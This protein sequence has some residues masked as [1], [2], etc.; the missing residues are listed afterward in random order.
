MARIPCSL[1]WMRCC[2]AVKSTIPVEL[3]GASPLCVAKSTF[4][5]V[6]G[7][8]LLAN[9]FLI[10]SCLALGACGIVTGNVFMLSA[11]N[12]FWGMRDTGGRSKG[13]SDLSDSDHRLLLLCRVF[14]FEKKDLLLGVSPEFFEELLYTTPREDSPSSAERR[15]LSG[16]TRVCWDS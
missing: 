5:G 10:F 11:G 9:F 8:L 3:S 2:S 13:C 6:G 12:R 15:V 4:G 7:T 16:A 1:T 14:S